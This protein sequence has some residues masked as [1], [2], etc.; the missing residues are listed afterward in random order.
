VIKGRIDGFREKMAKAVDKARAIPGKKEVIF[1]NM[2]ETPTMFS[3][4]VEKGSCYA[5]KN[6]D[7]NDLPPTDG[8]TDD[9]RGFSALCYHSTSAAFNREV[10]LGEGHPRW[11][12]MTM[13]CMPPGDG[14]RRDMERAIEWLEENFADFPGLRP[15]KYE[16]ETSQLGRMDKPLFQAEMVELAKRMKKYEEKRNHGSRV[17]LLKNHFLKKTKSLKAKI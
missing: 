14:R 4:A 11:T 1:I 5:L 7:K 15:V 9:K 12:S 2:D 3:Y 13:F 10:L 6:V 16:N 8:Q 17:R